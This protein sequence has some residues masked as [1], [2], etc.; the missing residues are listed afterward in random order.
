MFE[1]VPERGIKVAGGVDGVL[2]EEAEVGGVLAAIKVV[3]E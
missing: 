1:K 2:E 3:G